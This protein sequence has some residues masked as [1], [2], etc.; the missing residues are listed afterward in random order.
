MASPPPMDFGQLERLVATFESGSLGKAAALLNIPQASLSKTLY[1]LEADFGGRLFER[2]TRKVIPTAF[3]KLVYVRTKKILAELRQLENERVALA[4]GPVGHVTVGIARGTGFLGGVIPA[5][6]AQLARGSYSIH[7]TVVSGVAEELIR[8]LQLGDLDFAVAVLDTTV[9]RA[10]LQAEVLFYDRLGMFVDARHPLAKRGAV[11][12]QELATYC[13]LHSTDADSLQEA[14][15]RLAHHNG[16]EP[17]ATHVDSNSVVYLVSTLMGSE[18]V[19]LLSMDS[20]EEQVVAGKLVEIAL[21]PAQRTQVPIGAVER[22]IVF[23]RRTDSELSPVSVAMQ[24]EIHALCA[25]RSYPLVPALSLTC[26]SP[27]GEGER[28]RARR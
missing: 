13:W 11:E 22:P 14:L 17:R 16:V 4:G 24:R 9:A 7:L 3:G 18:F 19:G 27:P 23:L 2:G 25:K 20:V 12:I 26:D 8:A 10:D 15:V 1:Q 21:D 5:A 28:P 6:S